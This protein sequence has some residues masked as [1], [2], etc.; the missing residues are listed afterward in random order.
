LKE[1]AMS[2]RYPVTRSQVQVTLLCFLIVKLGLISVFVC[3]KR[4][5]F[6]VPILES[7]VALAKDAQEK[8]TKD[9]AP[10]SAS[11]LQTSPD[12]RQPGASSVALEQTRAQIEVERRRLEEERKQLTA[13]KQEIDVKL[14]RLEKMQ[15]AVQSKLDEQKVLGN[16]R[17]KQ[18]IKIYTTMPP[19]KAAG[20][21]EKLD[22]NVII[23]LFSKMKGE[24]VGQI[25]PYVSAEKAAAISERL[26]R[27]GVP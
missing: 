18:L 3:A 12:S 27:Q 23:S 22:M 25:L 19:K 2:G 17:M 15:D 21:I 5:V 24:N 16:Q 9:R 13:L 26:V 4:P 7:N 6:P 8:P 11:A 10:D 14:G 1:I 20:L